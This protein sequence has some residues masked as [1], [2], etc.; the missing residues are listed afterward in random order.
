[1][2]EQPSCHPP[3]RWP[4]GLVHPSSQG[5]RRASFPRSIPSRPPTFAT[6][7]STGW[8]GSWGV[9]GYVSAWNGRPAGERL[10]VSWRV[11]DDLG[12]VLASNRQAAKVAPM[13]AVKFPLSAPVSPSG[14]YR[15]AAEVRGRGATQTMRYRCLV[16]PPGP[17]QSLCL[18]GAWK[19]A[20]ADQEP[21][22]P[23]ASGWE[24]VTVPSSFDGRDYNHFWYRRGPSLLATRPPARP[25]F[26]AQADAWQLPPPPQRR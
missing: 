12:R 19:L 9:K 1:M 15:L 22:A 23:P 21:E 16:P 20:P 25:P 14:D 5:L 26:L 6:G 11:L 3:Q 2:P 18:A 7:I 8:A 4:R 17:R 24:P 13:G 10:E